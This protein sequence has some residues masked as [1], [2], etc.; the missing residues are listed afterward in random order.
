MVDIIN[1]KINHILNKNNTNI[2]NT[3][4]NNT[5]INKIKNIVFSGGASKG[6]AQLGALHYLYE[7]SILN[8]VVRVSGTSVGAMNALLYCIGYKTKRY[9]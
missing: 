8:N 4:I 2:N 9:L 3:N 7:K 1:K 6:V 5:N